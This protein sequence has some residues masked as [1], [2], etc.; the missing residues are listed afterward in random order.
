MKDGLRYPYLYNQSGITLQIRTRSYPEIYL[1]SVNI[2]WKPEDCF[3]LSNA[4]GSFINHLLTLQTGIII[5]FRYI[6][7]GSRKYMQV[8]G[9]SLRETSSRFAEEISKLNFQRLLQKHLNVQVN[10]GLLQGTNVS[11]KSCLQQNSFTQ[12][13]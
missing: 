9:L 13:Y 7:I 5:T 3:L 2:S 12:I 8:R 4:V 1:L 11:M 6:F 10:T